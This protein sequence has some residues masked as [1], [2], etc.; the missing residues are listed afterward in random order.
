MSNHSSTSISNP[1]KKMPQAIKVA[2]FAFAI[3]FCTGITL[4]IYSDS[5]EKLNPRSYVTPVISYLDLKKPDNLKVVFLGSSRIASC[6]KRD[7]FSKLSGI[8]QSKILILP[9]NGAGTW[10]ELLLCR[11]NPDLLNSSPLVIIEV[12]PWMFNKSCYPIGAG[13][14]A[15]L[16]W[17][18]FQE[19]LEFPDLNM[20]FL[21][22]SDYFFPFSQRRTLEEWSTIIYSFIIGKRPEPYQ[23]DSIPEYHYNQSAAYI[24]MTTDP[25]FSVQ[26]QI[27]LL[28][29]YE[30]AE[31]KAEYLW[32]LILLVEKKTKKIV[33]LQPPLRNEYIEVINN[34][35]ELFNAEMIYL[36]YIHSLEKDSVH[37]I[38]WE[39]P[40]DC[41]LNDSVL[42]DYGHFNNDG[43]YLFTQRLFNEIRSLGLIESENIPNNKIEE[44]THNLESSLKKNPNDYEKLYELGNLYL[45]INSTK[46][47]ECYQK[48][49]SIHPDNINAM[50]K[51]VMLYCDWG[52]YEKALLLLNR[53]KE[54]HPELAN[55][56][57]K[58][59]CIKAKQNR[60]NES[61]EW[62]TIAIEKGFHNRY[63][64]TAKDLDNIKEVPAYKSLLNKM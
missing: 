4:S 29:H 46:A 13:E 64:L 26:H 3:L 33:L 38:V 22:L 34:I 24:K 37:S 63:L 16:T 31:Y 58:I 6:I 35:P 20:R 44:Y 55:I 60:V 5:L 36:N 50:G 7:L 41:G 59:A 54:I 11:K 23:P 27:G 53:F 39:R 52:E 42:I 62:L 61:I 56:Y 49:L 43:A 9:S 40:E 1:Q 17:S 2:L 10:E 14:T 48:S 30:F 47:I 45:K 32:R 21:L 12:D 28:N 25:V 15:F 19:R 57:Y 51:L 8:E 18:T